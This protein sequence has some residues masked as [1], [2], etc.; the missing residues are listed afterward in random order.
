MYKIMF[1]EFVASIKI[2]QFFTNI[3]HNIGQSYMLT[4]CEKTALK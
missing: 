1:D 2:G 4:A 3:E